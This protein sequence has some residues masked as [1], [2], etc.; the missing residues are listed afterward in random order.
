MGCPIGGGFAL[1]GPVSY[2]CTCLT[3]YLP[4]PG[5]QNIFYTLESPEASEF[6]STVQSVCLHTEPLTGRV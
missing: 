4:T 5:L 2:L 6:L 1:L 3:F